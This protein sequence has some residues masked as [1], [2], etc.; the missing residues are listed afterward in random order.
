MRLLALALGF[1]LSTASWAA[2]GKLL[3]VLPLLLD[4]KGRHALSPSLFERDAYQAQ[5]RKHIDLVSG[6]RFDIQWKVKGAAPGDLTLRLEVRASKQPGAKPVLREVPLKQ[7]WSGWG[8][9]SIEFK[10]Q[11]FADLGEI[12]AWHASILESGQTLG[13]ISSFLW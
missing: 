12:L 2:D 6:V 11:E 1:C 8:W 9:S 3:K 5:L 7:S 10:D 4:K 13:E